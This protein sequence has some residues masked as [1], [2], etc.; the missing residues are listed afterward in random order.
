MAEKKDVEALKIFSFIRA[1]LKKKQAEKKKGKS[2]RSE[3]K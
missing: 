1:V 3:K 2:V